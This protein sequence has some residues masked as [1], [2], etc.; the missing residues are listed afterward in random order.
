LVI[1]KKVSYIV[2]ALTGEFR[3]DMKT[4]QWY[5]QQL[6]LNA[7]HETAIALMNRLNVND[8]LE[9]I[10]KRA[11]EILKTPH[12]FVYLVQ[13]EVDALVLKVGIGTYQ[14]YLG[15]HRKK[16]ERA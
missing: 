14:S 15:V 3:A 2:S 4:E 11:C 1:T 13:P 16:D 5:Q 6:Y 12:G 9:T 7:L 10:V 8:L